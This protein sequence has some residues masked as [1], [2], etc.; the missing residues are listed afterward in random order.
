MRADDLFHADHIVVLEPLQQLDLPYSRDWETFLFIFHADFF[1]CH[2]RSCSLFFCQKH[3]S[4]SPF[5]NHLQFAVAAY[6]QSQLPTFTLAERQA[7]TRVLVNTDLRSM[8]RHPPNAA[9]SVWLG[10]STIHLD[11]EGGSSAPLVLA[12]R[13]RT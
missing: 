9:S 7:G 6:N 12:M 2:F 11:A 4:I 8:L 13:R 5:P 10:I 1:E 3:L